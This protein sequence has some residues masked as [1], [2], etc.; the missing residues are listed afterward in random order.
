M[1]YKTGLIDYVIVGSRSIEEYAFQVCNFL[2]LIENC[3]HY[4][5]DKETFSTGN[6]MTIDV[7]YHNI[8]SYFDQIEKMVEQKET[9]KRF[10]YR[11][12]LSALHQNLLHIEK[13]DD[14]AKA[15]KRLCDKLLADAFES[16]VKTY[17]TL[18]FYKS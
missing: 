3:I 2:S 18:K 14:D 10:N 15:I 8:C 16:L 5:D 9:Y 11:D 7:C 1:K 6:C 17:P 13:E 4:S 12:Y